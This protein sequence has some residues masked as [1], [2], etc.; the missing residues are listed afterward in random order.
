[1]MMMI[2]K[3]GN[4]VDVVR[5]DTDITFIPVSESIRALKLFIVT[6]SKEPNSSDTVCT[7]IVVEYVEGLDLECIN[8]ACDNND[9]T[10]LIGA[11]ERHSA[12][13]NRLPGRGGKQTC[14]VR[15][16]MCMGVF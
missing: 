16:F 8:H 10:G 5:C 1:M 15:P 11:L 2:L 12:A 7:D 6:N 4:S 13:R 14:L 3:K 9:L